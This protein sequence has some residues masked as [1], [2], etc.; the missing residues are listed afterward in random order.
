V[1]IM[2]MHSDRLLR[3]HA[4]YSHLPGIYISRMAS[5]LDLTDRTHT[6]RAYDHI[7]SIIDPAG[8]VLLDLNQGTYFSLNGVGS[9]VWQQIQEG[10]SF[11]Q[12]ARFVAASCAVSEDKV[13]ADISR[14][15]TRLGQQGM[16]YVDR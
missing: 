10:A 9:L 15:L 13:E 12:I 5:P 6:L 1:I 11:C 16:I 4:L 7:K 14:F 2:S 8:A 3:C